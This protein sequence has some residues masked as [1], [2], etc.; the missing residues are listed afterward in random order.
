MMRKFNIIFGM[1]T[2]Y[3]TIFMC[4]GIFI[5]F[6]NTYKMAASSN[7]VIKY[8]ESSLIQYFTN[9]YGSS[10]TFEEKEDK[11]ILIENLENFF[12]GSLNSYYNNRDNDLSNDINNT[13]SIVACLG[14]I[15]YYKNEKK[16]FSTT[17]SSNDMF[18]RIMNACFDKGYTTRIDGTSMSKLNNCL[19]TLLKHTIPQKKEIQNGIIFIKS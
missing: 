10:V 9:E 4:M 16:E 15:N 7:D 6:N 13:C 5:K 1:I 8:S 19:T 14:M 2:F 11:K 18:V 12:Q 17:D 3:F